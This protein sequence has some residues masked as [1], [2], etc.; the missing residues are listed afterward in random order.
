M[1]TGYPLVWFVE[2]SAINFHRVAKRFMAL[3]RNSSWHK[4]LTILSFASCVGL[5]A[6]A[7]LGV[8]PDGDSAPGHQAPPGTMPHRTSEEQLEKPAL[9]V[10]EEPSGPLVPCNVNNSSLL[11]RVTGS[12]NSERAI[13]TRGQSRELKGTDS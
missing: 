7:L 2:N 13:H 5:K 3:T 6:L 10:A 12:S 8:L 11:C 1:C 9:Q 4:T